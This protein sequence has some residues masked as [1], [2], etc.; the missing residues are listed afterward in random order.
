MMAKDKTSDTT[1][2]ADRVSKKRAGRAG[3]IQF[4][5]GAHQRVTRRRKG[6]GR[7][8]STKSR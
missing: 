2:V 7:A 1:V 8:R 6:V 5:G 4:Y 3:C